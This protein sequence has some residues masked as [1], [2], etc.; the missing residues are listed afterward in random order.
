MAKR[1]LTALFGVSILVPF[2]IFSYTFPVIILTV[3]MSGLGV[4]EVLK[5][6]GKEK[7]IYLLVLKGVAQIVNCFVKLLLL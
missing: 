4:Y 6:I 3:F 5:C 7:N 2:A 1:L